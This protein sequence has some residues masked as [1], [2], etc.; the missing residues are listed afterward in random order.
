MIVQ[1]GREAYA[2]VE[3]SEDYKELLKAD[4]DGG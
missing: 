4:A 3:A 1:H 2:F